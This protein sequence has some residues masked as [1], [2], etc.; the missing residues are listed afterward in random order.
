MGTVRYTLDIGAELTYREDAVMGAEIAAAMGRPRIY[1]PD[2]PPLTD[3][4]LAEFEPVYHVRQN[5]AMA[6]A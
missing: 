6:L 2:C 5:R 3:A 1:D 4:E